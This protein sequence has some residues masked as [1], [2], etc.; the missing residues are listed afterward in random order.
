MSSVIAENTLLP[1]PKEFIQVG[2]T[3]IIGYNWMGVF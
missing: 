2:I 3:F 1:S